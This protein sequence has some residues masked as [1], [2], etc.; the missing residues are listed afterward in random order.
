MMKLLAR[1]P[2]A[3]VLLAGAAHAS[4][5][6]LDETP[7]FRVLGSADGLPSETVF[8]M[9]QDHSG[10]LWVGTADGLARFD[11]VEFRVYQQRLRDPGSLPSNVI[12]ALHVDATGRVW[13]GTERGGLSVLAPGQADF[14][15]Y[16]RSTH[17]AIQLDDVW[18]I[19]STADGA[20]WFGGY[21][22][23]LYRLDPADDQ[24]QV[25]QPRDEDSSALASPHVLALAVDA[26]GALWVGGSN[27]LQR[28]TGSGFERVDG[29]RS[30]MILSLSPGPD[31]G[32]WV[33]SSS[34]L[35]YRDSSGRIGPAPASAGLENRGVTAV[36]A[37][38]ADSLWIA[39]RSGLHRWQHG[40]LREQVLPS[41]RGHA[42]L[43]RGV[44]ELLQDH[45]G[46]LWFASI[47][48]GLLRLPPGWQ[49]FSVLRTDPQ[50]TSSL[51]S[52]APM[53]MATGD[54]DTLWVVG[55]DGGLDR[56]DPHTGRVQRLLA[57]S[58]ALPN[59][60]LSAVVQTKD[61]AVWLGHHLG[62]S[63]YQPDT[64]QL[65]HWLA[66]DDTEAPA[67]G[68]IDLLIDDGAG[69]L[70]LSAFGGGIERRDRNGKVLAWHRPGDGS[71]MV[72]AHTEQMLRGADGALWIASASGLA[73][74]DDASGRI[75]PVAGGPQ[76][77]VHAFAFDGADALW[78]HS[79]GALDRYRIEG[80]ALVL[81]KRVDG[82]QGLPEVEAGGLLV[83]ASGDVWLTTRRGLWRYRSA[84]GH[85]RNYGVRDG[86]SSQEF[87]D[88]PALQLADGVIAAASLD[89]LVLFHPQRLFEASGRP[90]LR[91]QHAYLQRDGE[92]R[93]LDPAAGLQLRHG[94]RELHVAARLVS[95]GDPD[96]HRYR[97]WLQGHDEGWI[98]SGALGERVYSLL[99][100]GNYRLL[101]D[102]AGSSGEWSDAPLEIPIVVAPAWWNSTAARVAQA[103]VLLL[104]LLGLWRL[105]RRRLA[106][107]HAHELAE[108]ERQWAL[109]T[110]EGKS[111]FLA[112][113]G[114]EIRTP[115]TGV[116]GMTELLLRSDLSD[117]QRGHA[118]AI[119]RSGELMLR[120]LNDALDLS[121][122]E[123]G[124]LPLETRPFDLARLVQEV[125]EQQRALVEARGLRFELQ[126]DASVPRWRQ[127]DLLRLK[128]VLLNLSGN[129]IKF[130]EHGFVALR[131]LAADPGFEVQVADSGPGLNEEQR[132]R[133]FQRF[134][135]ADG[136]ATARLHGGS[137]LGLAISQELVAAMGG[138]IV[139]ES[140][141]GQGSCFRVRLDLPVVQ[142]RFAP[143]EAAGEAV[144]AQP[145]RSLLLVE[146]D[147]TVAE[148][149]DELLAAAGYRVS[150]AGHGLAALG[151][152]AT[153]SFDL[154]ILDLDLPGIDGLTL[155]RMLR[156]Q[157]RQL[158]LLALTA[159]SDPAAEPDALAAGFN[160]FLR[161][162]V[163]LPTLIAAIEVLCEPSHADRLP[164]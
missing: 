20:I 79:L 75:E 61:G 34:G 57:D 147:A 5:S 138:H 31:G 113:L 24:M 112:T 18:A 139:V 92:K 132:A 60:R 122:I 64:G 13:V 146:D 45:E 41:P 121:R 97:F 22:G 164:V 55:K 33:G 126:I 68:P 14:G 43:A 39:T 91:L 4:A 63:R 19:T 58:D 153:Q 81:E 87:I 144:T 50:R 54:A 128:Q 98:E 88:R 26:A 118:A 7:R 1:I 27:G 154:A 30:K 62:L 77:R 67:Q 56:L 53:A 145:G 95:F 119:Q 76:G 51:S 104:L 37:D 109:R 137:G 71:G 117:R 17:P 116:L 100:A 161:K 69:G 49:D 93:W 156:E 74:R 8:A 89:S 42:P 120:L 29:M 159:R 65:A 21:G 142:D 101:I 162:P 38:G 114:H 133:L 158:P 143:D 82:A 85:W 110:S 163:D 125:A 16:R 90:R 123:S 47:G 72:D 12:Q 136:A 84:D 94:D 111:R 2:V 103:A 102:G 15:H 127:G 40:R 35:D 96:A 106:R 129:A 135:Q 80:G 70:W 99:P 148:V 160:R 108:R 155:A 52:P 32:L 23:G 48:G 83:D 157:G 59:R 66:R 151:E 73:R 78:T 6:L 124:K 46:G 10:Y 107:R 44:F 9:A 28:W 86:L 36:L 25:F 115:M 3:L 152:L 140:R 141:P 134:E 149:M 11:G 150:H 105:Q 131:L 130:T